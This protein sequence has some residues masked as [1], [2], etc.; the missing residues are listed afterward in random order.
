MPKI[1]KQKRIET[2]IKEY[3]DLFSGLSENDTEFLLDLFEELAFLKITL[4]DLKPQIMD[5]GSVEEYKHG[6][7]QYGTKV[8]SILNAYNN[9]Y[10]QYLNTW[11]Q[12]YPYL[13]KEKKDSKLTSFLNG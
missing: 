11:K 10:K 4:E 1:T 12:I 8:S 13:P 9:T 6:E 7:N 3:M 5:E 2:N